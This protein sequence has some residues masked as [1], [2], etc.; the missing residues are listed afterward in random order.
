MIK[1][2]KVTMKD[3][4]HIKMLKCAIHKKEIFN[5]NE[6]IH[7]ITNVAKDFGLKLFGS[8]SNANG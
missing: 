6:F 1:Y 5:N 2:K 8:T 3:I 7:A 4:N